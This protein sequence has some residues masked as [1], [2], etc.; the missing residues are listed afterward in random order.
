MQGHY[1]EAQAAANNTKKWAII[2][3]IVWAVLIACYILFV[4]VLG[5]F[6]LAVVGSNLPPTPTTHFHRY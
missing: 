3:A 4:V 1:A 5:V 2:S 6:S